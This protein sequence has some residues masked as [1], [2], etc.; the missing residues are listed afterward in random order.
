MLSDSE[1][2]NRALDLAERGRG[3]TSPNPMVGAV[4][5]RDD[6]TIVGQGY[7]ERAGG[8]H[9][10][11]RALDEAGDLA[12][13][14]S[15]YCTLEPC[16]H[17]G[18]T[19][20]CAER[21]ADAGITRVVAA[22]VDADERVSGRGFDFLR[23]R[24]IVVSI[25]TGRA[26]ALRLNRAYFTLKTKRRPFVVMKAAT[27]LDNR[28]AEAAGKRT[29]ITSDDSFRHAHTVR[30]EIDAIGVG[31]GTVLADDPLLTAREVH[32]RRP[33]TRVLFDRRLR[34]SPSAR[35]FSTLD[36]GPV[37][38]VTTP[39]S[40]ERERGRARELQQAGAEF[41]PIGSGGLPDAFH[42]LGDRQMMSIVLEGGVALHAAA[43]KAGVVDAVHLYIA[44]HTLGGDGLSWLD[45]DTIS[46]A[47]LEDRCVTP[48]GPDVFMEGY[49]HRID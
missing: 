19:G 2:M 37:I 5:V 13:G 42:R 46:I 1:Y 43:W 32:R 47:S 15:L 21:V 33:L 20:P 26:R 29:R 44:P 25:G 27:T 45:T 12:R 14:A 10:E 31:S 7:H 6:G 28:I 3:S 23:Q 36:A 41:E 49:V 11:V 4:V 48:L 8:P 38:I 18:R 40:I 17:V 34:I 9:A 22:T 39:E 35:L 24:N 30:A 16:A